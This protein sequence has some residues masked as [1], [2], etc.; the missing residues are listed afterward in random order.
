MKQTD[1][2]GIKKREYLK[3]R[4]I[5][6]ATKSENENIRDLYIGIH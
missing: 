4:I 1:I 5:E 3:D 2:S 6:L